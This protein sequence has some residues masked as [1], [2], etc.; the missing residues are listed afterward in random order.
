M[1]GS[2][3]LLQTAQTLSETKNPPT[4]WI[5]GFARGQGP[6]SQVDHLPPSNAQLRMNVCCHGVQTDLMFIGPCI[7]LIIE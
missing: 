3:S 6:G 2:F 1:A 7:I 5:R 4:A